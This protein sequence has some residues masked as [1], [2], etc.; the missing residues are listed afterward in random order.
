M[1]R[2]DEPL[3]SCRSDR[4]YSATVIFGSGKGARDLS[5]GRMEVATQQ[6][7]HPA[8]AGYF[9]EKNRLQWEQSNY[10]KLIALSVQH[11]ARQ[12]RVQRMQRST[13]YRASQTAKKR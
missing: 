1:K 3:E 12:L 11:R 9:I 5:R 6:A 2:R 13:R 4:H 8:R 10:N 7:T